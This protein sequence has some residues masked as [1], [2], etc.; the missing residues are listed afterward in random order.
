MDPNIKQYL[1]QIGSKGGKKSRR[2]LDSQDAR[3]MVLVR[4]ARRAFKKYYASCF[5]SYDPNYKIGI[6]DVSW[7]AE[8]LQKNGDLL[9]WKKSKQLCL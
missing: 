4:E 5:W 8:Q 1:S 7:V 3:D 9:A 2:R 6:G